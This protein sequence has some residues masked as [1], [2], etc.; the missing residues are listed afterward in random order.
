MKESCTRCRNNEAK[1]SIFDEGIYT[2]GGDFH[3]CKVGIY[4]GQL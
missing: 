4:A 3:H 2:D 1:V